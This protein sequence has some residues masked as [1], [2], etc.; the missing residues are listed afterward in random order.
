[1]SGMHLFLEKHHILPVFAG[2]SNQPE[3][4]VRLPPEHHTLAHF[5]RYLAYSQIGDK[6]A[7][8]MRRNQTNEGSLVRW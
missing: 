5:Y 3:N 1:M 8:T 4:L 7:Y 6:V 2:G